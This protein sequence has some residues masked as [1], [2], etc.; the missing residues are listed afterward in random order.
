MQ[1]GAVG[2]VCNGSVRDT[3]QIVALGFPVFCRGSYG[4]DQRGRGSVTDYGTPIRV[5]DATVRPRDLIVGDIDGVLVLPREAE[6]D[7]ISR[8]LEKARTES[9]VRKALLQGM[10][11][12]DAFAQYGV[13]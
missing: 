10:K 9:V 7:V 12:S 6:V 4:L 3:H 8:A 5:G 2:A 1:R 13:L 11:A